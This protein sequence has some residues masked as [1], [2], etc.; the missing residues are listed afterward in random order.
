MVQSLMSNATA[1]SA[2]SA[3]AV[4]QYRISQQQQEQ[5]PGALIDGGANGGLFGDDVRILKFVE[6]AYV[7]I[8]GINNHDVPNL[9]IAQGA[10]LLKQSTMA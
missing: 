3:N 10:V 2:Q 6:N 5:S 8:T 7:D 4:V 9:R 1:Q